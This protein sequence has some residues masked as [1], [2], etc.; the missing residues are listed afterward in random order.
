MAILEEDERRFEQD[1]ETFLLTEGGYVK[2]DQKSYD[3]SKLIDVKDLVDFIQ[4]TQ[5]KEWKRYTAIYGSDAQP[6]LVKRLN[7]EID[8][9]GLLHV[10]R[11][12]IKDRG[13]RIKVA[14]FR[15]ES[16]LNKE[17]IE[18]YQANNIKLFRQFAYSPNNHN[19]LDMA[20]T[21]NGIPVVAIELKNQL[22]GQNVQNAIRQFK[23]D[24]DP[25][26][27][28][29]QFNKR[30]L[31]YFAIDLY[32]AYMTTQL[33]G[34]DTHFLPFNQGSNGAGKVGGAGNPPNPGGYS[35][36]YVW[37]RVLQ[38]DVLMDILQRYMLLEG[39]LSS[40]RLI[41]PRYHQLDV[42]SKLLHNVSANGSGKKYLIQH[43]TGSGKTNSIAW[44]AFRLASIHD[45][46]N[47]NIFSSVIVVS[48]RKT[49]D[50]NLQEAISGFDNVAGL[51][52]TIGQDK[53]SK[54]LK[55]A[56]NN[57][58][59]II[60]TTLQKFPQIYEEVHEVNGR[61]FAVIIDEA[62]S[63]QTGA[64]AQKLKESLADTK[65][66]LQEYREIEESL[67]EK[68]PDIQD[69]LV[70]ELLK[71]GEHNNLSF[72]AFTATPK[73]RTLEKFGIK[74]KEGSYRPFHVY[75]MRQ[76]I[77]EG[78]IL[79]TLNH[80]TTYKSALRIARNTSDNPELSKSAAMQAI[81]RFG[82][83][84]HDNLNAKT[85]IMIKH[86]RKNTKDKIN[87]RAKAMVVTPSR[88]HAVRYYHLFNQHINEYGYTDVKPLVAFTGT[89]LE[90]NGEEYTES[91]LNKT[92]NGRT[93]SGNQIED[94]F[95]SDDFNV[96]IVAE[97]FQTGFDEPYLHTMYVDKRLKNIKA[98]QTISRLNRTAPGK[99]DTFVLD[100]VNEAEEIQ[101]AFEPY[102]TETTLTEEVDINMIY[103]IQSKLR[104]YS[105][106]TN[107]D[108]ERVLAI[109]QEG[110]SQDETALGQFTS[111]LIPII[112][113]YES[114]EE[115][116]KYIFRS[117]LN[118]FVKGYSRIT[119]LVRL[120]DK[121]LHEE[122]TFA[123]YLIRL[124]P[125]NR[126]ETVNL[127][128]KIRL[129]YYHLEKDFEG[130]ISLRPEE[131]EG[132]LPPDKLVGSS[133]RPTETKEALDKIIDRVNA[134]VADASVNLSEEEK[135]KAYII[136]ETIFN[137]A[138]QNVKLKRYV[139]ENNKEMFEK[140]IFPSEFQKLA[141][142]SAGEDKEDVF[143]LLFREQSFY[144][145]AL[146]DIGEEVYYELSK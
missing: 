55:E 109:Y 113:E 12:G 47:E 128:D 32:E 23:Y 136:Y 132:T 71:Q 11:Y 44:L 24:R 101:E 100:F 16:D 108:V 42:V 130:D 33:K 10:L 31:V 134:R 110:S 73:A 58:K 112:T 140:S 84:H 34:A 29:F 144:D 59:K 35:T 118:S 61:K 1:I 14:A 138:T 48:D 72:F 76:A 137:K 98:V 26:E 67:E 119:Q 89:V 90:D 127:E 5:P 22:K 92:K 52:E 68:E 7:Q 99:E 54:D 104:E 18:A 65:E 2:G 133:Q 116:Q 85:E 78:F 19:T 25:N 64:S 146:E 63:S 50:K 20:I 115:D 45:K 53:T 46:N 93:L 80:Y 96:L 94:A 8:N 57:G 56:V 117:T 123:K 38:K 142:E 120:Y 77:E 121:E 141:L 87:G 145:G 124:I 83:L 74:D 75:S 15:P 81:S 36:S 91:K 6:Q 9:K 95:H 4:E 79:D 17:V 105:I 27:L 82:S 102:F 107:R 21:L 135:P 39:D 62:H 69:K 86:F 66:S 114:L 143:E 126:H 70:D 129:E 40:G 28:A 41:F 131:V 37:E 30:F 60:V 51:I 106:Y 13:I 3:K 43:S 139:E 88:K 111:A 103:D 122:Y 97:K 49:L 125:R